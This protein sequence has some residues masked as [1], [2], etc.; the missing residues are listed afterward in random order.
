MSTSW[1]CSASDPPIR[2]SSG[3][4]RQ[5]V[6]WQPMPQ[7]ANSFPQYSQA[8]WP[9]RKSPEALIGC[10]W[11][12][13]MLQ[14]MDGPMHIYWP[15][16]CCQNVCSV[17]D[18]V[19]FGNWII[20]VHILQDFQCVPPVSSSSERRSVLS[21][22]V[23]NRLP[24]ISLSCTIALLS[25]LEAM[26][27]RI[28]TYYIEIGLRRKEWKHSKIVG[29]ECSASLQKG[30]AHLGWFPNGC[31]ECHVVAK[32]SHGMAKSPSKMQ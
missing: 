17:I 16:S 25:H 24:F 18:I 1:C 11:L 26:V 13:G 2:V 10:C 12:L 29:D 19:P 6:L 4:N 3:R 8:S 7:A 31:N 15:E 21:C 14:I 20:I 27:Q 28:S 5:D 9:L 23:W 32:S 22:W 30:P